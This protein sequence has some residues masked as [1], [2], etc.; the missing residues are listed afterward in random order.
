MSDVLLNSAL[1]YAKRGWFVFPCR[2][3]TKEPAIERGFYNSTTNPETIKRYWSERDRNVG[4]RTG[5]ASGFW[6]L[7]IDGDDGA[8]SLRALEVKHGRLPATREVITERGRHLW[9]RC[10][11]EVK[12]STSKIAPGIDTKGDGGY[13]MAPSSIHPSGHRYAW[14]NDS[15]E[16]AI[17][18][19][20]LLDAL[21]KPIPLPTSERSLPQVRGPSRYGRAALERECKSLAAMLPD[22]GRNSALNLKAF[23]LGQLV[24]GGELFL[25][26]VIKH[27]LYACFRNQLVADT[28]QRAVLATIA[29]GLNAGM[30]SPRTRSAHH[31]RA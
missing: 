10:T 18:P 11:R 22:T 24:A 5:V 16:L 15:I 17:A 13:V 8:A 27:L 2:P 12:C 9:F 26:E 23:R 3:R 1:E 25:D 28:S 19:D 6:V 7:D 21:R 31:G 14:L 4:I 30:K 20:W 29:S